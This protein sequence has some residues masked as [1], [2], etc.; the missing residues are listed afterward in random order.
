IWDRAKDAVDGRV[1]DY[2]GSLVA[3]VEAKAKQLRCPIYPYHKR[4][5]VLRI[6]HLKFIHGFFAGVTAARQHA[7]AYGSCLF[8]HVHAVDGVSG[9][10][11]D[12]RVARSVGAL[13]G[14]DIDYNRASVNSLRHCNGWAY[15]VIDDTSGEYQVFQAEAINGRFYVAAEV[16]VM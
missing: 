10:G 7:L 12:R 4:L 15:G 3:Q 1:R 11:V 14:V 2:A 8:G 5:G 9:P 6:G 13:C 16:R